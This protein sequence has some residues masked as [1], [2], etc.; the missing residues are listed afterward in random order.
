ME[1]EKEKEIVHN[2]VVLSEKNVI[3]FAI[4]IYIYS[5]TLI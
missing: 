5:V 4:Y 3:V 1:R 2:I